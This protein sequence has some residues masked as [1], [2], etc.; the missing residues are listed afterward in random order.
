MKTFKNQYDFY[1]LPEDQRA[2]LLG[3]FFK[4]EGKEDF[5]FVFDLEDENTNYGV[6][7]GVVRVSAIMSYD[8][9]KN[10]F[11][12]NV[13]SPD[14][15]DMDFDFVGLQDLRH[16]RRRV[17][18]FMLGVKKQDTSYKNVFAALQERFP[19]GERTS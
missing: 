5:Y 2:A 17:L 12:V 8:H 3:S 13:F 15:L 7:Q 6:K 9:K 4:V 16:L 18:G 19:M 1:R 11:R 10:W 14:D